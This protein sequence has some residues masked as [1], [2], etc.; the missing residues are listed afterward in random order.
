MTAAREKIDGVVRRMQQRDDKQRAAFAAWQRSKDRCLA[1]AQSLLD[2]T[3]AK[4]VYDGL[5][6]GLLLTAKHGSFARFVFD[7]Q[8]LALVG[9]RGKE[10]EA[11]EPFFSL[12]IEPPARPQGYAQGQWGP[13][14]PD[15]IGDISAKVG[16]QEAFEKAV[17]DWFEWAH[18]GDGAPPAAS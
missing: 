10:G 18:I 8:Q 17:A 9:T 3:Q 4:A 15:G 2:G 13:S 14:R 5:A 6:A 7:S 11:G 16:T 1:I 12:K